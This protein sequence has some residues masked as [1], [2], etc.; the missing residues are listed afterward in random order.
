VIRVPGRGCPNAPSDELSVARIGIFYHS[1]PAGAVPSG[2][3]SIIRGILQWAPAD[4]DYTLYGASSDPAARPVSQEVAIVLGGRTVRYVPLIHVDPNADRGLVPNTVRYMHALERAARADRLAALHVLD[5]HRIEPVWLF[6]RD[7]RPKNVILHQDMS[8][9]RGN[10]TDIK[11]RYCPWLYERL[12]ASLFR[13]IDNVFC[14][15]E[16]AVARYSKRYSQD[17]TKFSFLPT[18]VDTL[19][20]H[21]PGPQDEARR[22]AIRS[23]WRLPRAARLLIF[24]GRFD[25]QKD[26]LSLLAAFGRAATRCED[27]H[28]AMVGDGV[29]R[30]R[31]EQTIASAGLGA[32]VTLT[33]ALS[34]E[35]IAELLR[36]ADLFVLSSAYEGMPIAV[37]EAL[38]TGLPVVSTDVGELR[39]V[40][41][42][43]INGRLCP[44]GAPE[45]LAAAINDA[46]D[47]VGTMRGEPC[48]R[49]VLPYHPER[50]LSQLYAN[51][52]RQAQV[53]LA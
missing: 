1:D 31:I 50:V 47:G 49:S 52:R 11:W 43:G 41:R 10:T 24:V 19:V 4:L 46:L 32:R 33:G 37:L 17:V 7:R 18:W 3:D 13:S 12:E 35:T 23:Q 27:L 48:E 51:H 5:F 21:P 30:P 29:L 34:R 20:F 28:L 14:V 15:R 26:P 22:G 6:R 45:A 16:S 2:I 8:V 38:A 25:V 39:R 42:D 44:C 53:S 40:I 9:I 36:A